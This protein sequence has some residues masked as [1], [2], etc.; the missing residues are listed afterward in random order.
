LPLEEQFPA[1]DPSRG[2]PDGIVVLGGGLDMQASAARGLPELN[3]AAERMT[4]TVEL[5][6]KYPAVRIVFSG[7]DAGLI[8][9]GNEADFALAFFESLG[10]PQERVLFENQSRNTIENAE[11]SKSLAG[12]KPGE[13]WLIVTSAFHM[14]RAIGV[15]RA[16]G[17]AVE[18]YPVD[19]RTRGRG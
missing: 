14:P 8:T 6:R 18:A 15:F 10:L 19:W 11:F 3:E 4:A 1:W 12:P 2:D 13:R 16:V 7:G 17:F 5:A 9:S